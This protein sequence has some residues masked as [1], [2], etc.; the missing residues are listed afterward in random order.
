ME[1]PHS[2]MDFCA[3]FMG[4]SHSIDRTLAQKRRK[5]GKLTFK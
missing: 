3:N 1:T 4:N 5:M 2:L